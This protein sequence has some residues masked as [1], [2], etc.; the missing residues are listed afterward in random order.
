MNGAYLASDPLTGAHV[1][2]PSHRGEFFEVYSDNIS[3]SYSEVY[4]T[5]QPP[6]D[7]PTDFVKRFDGKVV[8]FTGYEVDSVYTAPNGTETSVPITAQYNHHHN[9][10]LLSKATKMVHVGPVGSDSTPTH[11]G[12]RSEWEPRLL[13]GVENRIGPL[14]SAALD[15]ASVPIM[16]AGFFVDGNG[17]EC[18]D[19][20]LCVNAAS[21]IAC[22]ADVRVRRSTPHP[23]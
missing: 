20:M 1:A 19:V 10:Y 2:A 17:G 3:T 4:W 13:P 8:A 5:M 9:C 22:V 11:G 14:A 7:L 6:Q 23:V 15:S 16:H 18:V 12:M 21:H